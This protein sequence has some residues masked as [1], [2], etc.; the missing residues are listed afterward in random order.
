MRKKHSAKRTIETQARE[1]KKQKKNFYLANSTKDDDK[2]L[3]PVCLIE[4]T[5]TEHE[6]EK[7]NSL[8]YSVFMDFSDGKG[9]YLEVEFELSSIRLCAVKEAAVMITSLFEEGTETL[10]THV[11][12]V[13]ST[14][15]GR[16]CRFKV[17]RP[18][19]NLI[20]WLGTHAGKKF[21]YD[22]LDFVTEHVLHS[23]IYQIMSEDQLYKEC[24][25]HGVENVIADLEDTQI[26]LTESIVTRLKTINNT[27][28]R[29]VL[30]AE[31][32]VALYA[33]HKLYQ[34]I[35]QSERFV[36]VDIEN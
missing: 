27:E 3:E 30:E 33:I 17:Y 23:R 18:S 9:M 29:K 10:G 14:H 31:A 24:E 19:N 11:E 21:P 32:K 36:F 1:S 35:L 22:D 20:C 7:S 28:R 12:P 6:R 26:G 5:K 13:F 2:S 8:P 16:R 4:E 34:L 25:K 15:N